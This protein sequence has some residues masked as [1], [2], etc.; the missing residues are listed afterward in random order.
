MIRTLARKALQTVAAESLP[1]STLVS[2]LVP[3]TQIASGALVATQ[4]AASER[5]SITLTIDCGSGD[6]KAEGAAHLFDHA[7][8]QAA[9]HLRDTFEKIGASVTS[10]VGR[11]MTAVTATVPASDVETAIAGLAELTTVSV[12]GNSLEAARIGALADVEVA[13][14]PATLVM[15][16]LHETA[17][18]GSALGKP[19]VGSSDAIASLT[20]DDVNAVSANFCGAKS[21]I[22]ASGAVDASTVATL[23][24][25]YF[26]SMNS[27]AAA[28]SSTV[29]YIG[30]D[31]RFREDD[32]GFAQVAVGVETGGWTDQNA[33][34]MM[35]AQHILGSWDRNGAGGTSTPSILATGLGEERHATSFNTFLHFFRG[36]GIF[37]VNFA[38]TDATL[39]D[40]CYHVM[41][42]L[43]RLQHIVSEAEVAYGKEKLKTALLAK[44]LGTA[45]LSAQ[46]GEQLLNVGRVVSAAEMY[47]RAEAVDAAAVQAACKEYADTDHVLAAAG[48]L[49]EL[50]SY[51]WF[52]NRTR[53]LAF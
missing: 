23:A 3:H 40:S 45:S 39:Q 42:N 13:Q 6:D 16:A 10:T 52:R 34:P 18:Q 25:K 12:D 24:E 2:P 35:V 31:V 4:P 51:D 43:V 9:P 36:S 14:A 20:V 46:M 26:G 15:D 11:E 53:W 5:V 19:I 28:D 8:Y 27:G 29:R 22:T 17:F 44:P 48:Q 50:P 32:L 7:M 38:C 21:V 37:G 33:V 41:Q 30:S 1:A 49:H 47:A